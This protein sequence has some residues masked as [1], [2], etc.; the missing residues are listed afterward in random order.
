MKVGL[1]A[2]SY[3]IDITQKCAVAFLGRRP[4]VES[5]G[6]MVEPRREALIDGVVS[7]S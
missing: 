2:I 7:V 4:L 1:A 6:P 3:G 5:F